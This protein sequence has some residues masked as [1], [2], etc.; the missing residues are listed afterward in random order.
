MDNRQ[1]YD[2]EQTKV[3]ET[4]LPIKTTMASSR[5]IIAE[6]TIEEIKNEDS[7]ETVFHSFGSFDGNIDNNFEE[8]IQEETS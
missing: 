3:E 4:N 8:E 2:L 5:N 6:N 1:Y 7:D